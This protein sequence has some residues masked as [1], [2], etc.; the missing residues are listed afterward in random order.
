[1]DVVNLALWDASVID[2]TTT[3][4]Q[5]LVFVFVDLKL[6]VVKERSLFNQSVCRRCWQ[7]FPRV[8]NLSDTIYC[9]GQPEIR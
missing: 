7:N 6:W 1:M 3:R 4:D 9:S 8:A 2:L 5:W